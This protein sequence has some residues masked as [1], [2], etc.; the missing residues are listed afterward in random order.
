MS[1][2]ASEGY[3]M[4][5]EWAQHS[6]T[7]MAWPCREEMWDT[8]GDEALEH[9]RSAHADVARAIAGFEPVTM[10]CNPGDVA[11]ASLACGPG[12]EIISLPIDDSWLRDSGPTFLVHQNG[13]LAGVDWRFNAWG[14]KY[15]PYDKDAAVAEKILEKAGVKRFQAPLVLEGGSIHVDGEGTL[16]ATEDCLLNPNRNPGLTRQDVEQALRDHLGVSQIL[17]LPG[18]LEDDETDGHIDNVASFAR[19]GVV[20]ALST[21]DQSDG[22]YAMLQENLARL[23]AATDAKGRPLEV[24]EVPQPSRRPHPAG[25][26]MAL[27]YINF[28]FVNGGIILP[29]FESPEDTKVFR[30]FRDTF[31]DRKV[32]Q[33]LTADIVLGGGGIHCITQQQPAPL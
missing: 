11:D 19:P 3:F 6:R 30:L 1:T 12:V 23:R 8:A 15:R 5:G 13:S 27:S 7:W 25:G 33:V 10:V 14:E 28:A 9:A 21:D 32:V 18:G 31:P 2:P 20:L 17:W 26:R 22:N 24:I 16:I 29:A 4:P